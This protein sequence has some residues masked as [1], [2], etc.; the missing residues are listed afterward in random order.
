MDLEKIKKANTTYLGKNILYFPEATSTQDIAK[1]TKVESGTVVITDNQTKGKG[2]KDRKWFVSKEKNITMT[3]VLYPN[4]EITKLDGLTIQIAT[5]IKQ[6]I[7]KL[8][9]YELNIK[10][11]NDLVLNGKKIAG[12]LTESKSI[13]NQ[14]TSL[15][16]GIGFN[17]NEE[18]F[19]E[20][21]R[22]IAT[23]LKREYKKEFVREEVICSILE[24]IEQMLSLRGIT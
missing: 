7:F 14:V 10:E 16:I 12:I 6:A 11:P 22:D 8:Y 15:Y 20:E 2:T 21:I 3:L 17:V 13:Q 23:S 18:E 19:A 5:A 4:V 9:G 24:E 1:Q